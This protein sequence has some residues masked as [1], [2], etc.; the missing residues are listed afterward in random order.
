MRLRHS[1]T[2]HSRESGLPDG[3]YYAVIPEE[4]PGKI[5]RVSTPEDRRHAY[6][7]VIMDGHIRLL[8][9]PPKAWIPEEKPRRLLQGCA[10]RQNR[11]PGLST[12][13]HRAPFR[14][15]QPAPGA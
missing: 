1:K 14:A 12:L 2:G 5:A 3:P 15:R 11:R 13:L 6:P 4:K 10:A 7:F 8:M 9:V